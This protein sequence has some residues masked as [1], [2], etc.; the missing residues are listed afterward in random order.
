M[1]NDHFY[2]SHSFK[3]LMKQVKFHQ[4]LLEKQQLEIDHVLLSLEQQVESMEQSLVK[5][6]EFLE[7]LD[8]KFVSL[9]KE[10]DFYDR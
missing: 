3:E 2:V 7:S 1:L 6:N 5:L 4:Q 10:F 9:D 8:F